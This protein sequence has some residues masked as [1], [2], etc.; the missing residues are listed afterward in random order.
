MRKFSDFGPKEIENETEFTKK[1]FW[2]KEKLREI[3]FSLTR[4]SSM[5]L[6]L[7]IPVPKWEQ[8]RKIW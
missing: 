2:Q 4:A 6:E 7:G 3:Y 8:N 5:A 1:N